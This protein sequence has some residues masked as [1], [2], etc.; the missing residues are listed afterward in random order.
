MLSSLVAHSWVPTTDPSRIHL[1]QGV[2][3]T[4]E[5]SCTSTTTYALVVCSSMHRDSC[6]FLLY[7]VS[8]VDRLCHLFHFNTICLYNF[9]QAVGIGRYS[10]RLHLSTALIIDYNSDIWCNSLNSSTCNMHNLLRV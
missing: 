1:I 9:E 4:N 8:A 10:L 7:S 3:V 2:E 5:W 6:T